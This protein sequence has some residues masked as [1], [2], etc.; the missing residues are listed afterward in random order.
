MV[1]ILAI[2]RNTIECRAQ[3]LS[4]QSFAHVV[5]AFVGTL[6]ATFTRKHTCRIFALAL[7]RINARSVRELAGEVLSQ[8]PLQYL[9]PCFKAWHCYLWYLQVAQ[10]FC[11]RLYLQFLIPYPEAVILIGILLLLVFPAFQHS[12]VLRV[13]VHFCFAVYLLQCFYQAIFIFSIA[14]LQHF[15]RF[16][17]S[18]ELLRYYALVFGPLVVLAVVL[19][20]LAQVAGAA[21]R[22]D[23]DLLAHLVSNGVL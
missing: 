15:Y 13:K 2:E 21:W 8:R 23:V 19:G 6:W 1:R 11:V 10:R 12:L 16:L 18:E 4:R 9:A 7:E 22:N 5:E 20:Y 14:C 17:Q 3:T